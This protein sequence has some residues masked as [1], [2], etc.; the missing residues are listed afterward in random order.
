[1]EL[2]AFAIKFIL[3]ILSPLYAMATAVGS[4]VDDSPDSFVSVRIYHAEI[5]ILDVWLVSRNRVAHACDA[6][7]CLTNRPS[8]NSYSLRPST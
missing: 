3:G 6:T 8:W 2:E 7:F 4:V 1:M 5:S